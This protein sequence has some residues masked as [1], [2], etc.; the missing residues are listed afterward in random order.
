MKEDSMNQKHQDD[1]HQAGTLA[2]S[3]KS[4]NVPAGF[5]LAA[6]GDLIITDAIHARLRRTAPELLALLQNADATFGNFEGTA[7]DL[8]KFGGHP[9]ALAG[10]SWLI[11]TP[12]VAPDLKLMGF[13]LISRANNHTTDWGVEGM[14]YTDR[15]FEQAGMVH[16]GTGETLARA[17]APAF[18]STPAGRVSLVAL[19]SRFEAN[20]RAIDPLGQIPGRPGLNALRTTRF[21]Q[22][23]PQRLAVL[24]GIRDALPKGMVR[25]SV[26]AADERNGTVTLF[27]IKYQAVEGLGE[28]VGFT[29]AMDERD[30]KAIL[31]NVRQAKQTSDFSVVSIHT[32]EP[33]NYS[34]LP[35]DFMPAIAR[36]A[37][38]QG[39]DAVVGH[40]PHQ[41]RG[42]EIYQGKPIYYS[43]GNF[44]FMENQQQPI[45]RDEFEKDKVEPMS[46]T[47][48][49]FMEHRRVHGVFK[50]QVW[51]ESVVAVN[52]YDAD[53]SLDEII[54]HPIEMH[55]ENER[56]A[57][58]GIPRLAGGDDAQRILARLQRLSQHYGTMIAIDG[59]LGRI[60]MR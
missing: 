33:G 43:L 17:R 6:V 58:R 48:A 59:G 35:P 10:G 2:P 51:Y 1:T 3:W 32:H 4:A 11:S 29:F 24:A 28:G 39:A 23:S 53:G 46:M 44:F 21:V 15:L 7:I 50:E 34:E 9:S 52:R 31:H 13:N 41:L 36:E 8:Q 42:I 22:V 20:A 12:A 18:L 40:G 5:T 47:E 19:A 55:W 57:D 30:R 25:K 38:D 16:A 37:I 49:E 56:D 60:S 27:D 45:T 26:L 54:L 14:R